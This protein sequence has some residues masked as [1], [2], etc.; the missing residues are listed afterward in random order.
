MPV[1][2]RSTL[3]RGPATVTFNGVTWY[4]AGDVAIKINKATFPV[5]VGGGKIDERVADY[6]AE[7]TFTPSGRLLGLALFNAFGTMALGTQLY[8]SADLPVVVANVAATWTF[9]AGRISKIPSIIASAR[10]TA[11]GPM[12]LKCIVGDGLV[13]G[14]ADSF[15]TMS[16]GAAPTGEAA[17]GIITGPWTI[18]GGT[19]GSSWETED[20]LTLDF[21]LETS[22][23]RTD[24]G[25]LVGEYLTG[26]TARAS[27]VPVGLAPSAIVTGLQLTDAIGAS[28]N[29][30][31]V[32][33]V[34]TTSGLTAT[35]K[36]ASLTEANFS[37]TVQNDPVRGVVATATRASNTTLQALFT[38]A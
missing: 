21:E 34:A 16:A 5:T 8:T 14:A 36:G 31:G 6:S 7:V 12:T 10:K 22:E 33:L 37:A 13:P 20:G 15:L 18:S 32:D 19:L 28:L 25:G 4:S 2:A 1:I 17:A 27:F 26:V 38:L 29:T 35:L 9:K 30:G 23:Q 24:S 3:V 11:F